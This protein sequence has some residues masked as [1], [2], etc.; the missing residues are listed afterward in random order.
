M[1]VRDRISMGTPKQEAESLKAELVEEWKQNSVDSEKPLII[2][3]TPRN[4]IH[5]FVVWDKWEGVGMEDRGEIIMSAFKEIERDELELLK[6]SIVMGLTKKEAPRF[7][8]DPDD[9]L[10]MSPQS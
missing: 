7:G 10:R 4:R 2:K 9:Y 1:P 5:I 8:I 3:D 6:V